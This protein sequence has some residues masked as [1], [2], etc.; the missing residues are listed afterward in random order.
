MTI[1]APTSSADTSAFHIIQ[2]V[3]EYQSSTSP[4]PR[5]HDSAWFFR[6]SRTMPPWPC[7]IAFGWPV[8]PEENSTTS[9]WSKGT[10]V[11]SASARSDAA[12]SSRPRRRAVDA[13]VAVLDV[14]HVRGPS[15]GRPTISATSARAVDVLAAVAVAA[16]DEQDHRLDLPEAVDHAARPELDRAAGPH[17]AEPGG[18]QERD[19]RLRAVG[20]VA[21]H[22]V[23]G[24]RR[25]GRRAPGGRAPPAARSSPQVSSRSGPGLRARQDGD[26][27]HRRAPAPRSACSA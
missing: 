11:V 23:A 15:A 6:C 21:G 5:S 4:R 8:V 9:G 14:E 3:V 12:S 2:A 1:E 17:R 18:G 26:A 10:G 25:R 20:Q 24:A 13:P 22:P 27:R 19:Q 16:G 7:T